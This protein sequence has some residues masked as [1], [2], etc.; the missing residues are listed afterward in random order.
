[1]V[2]SIVWGVPGQDAVLATVAGVPGIVGGAAD[3]VNA[4]THGIGSGLGPL[5]RPEPPAP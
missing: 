4:G 1:M 2:S 5:G 3:R